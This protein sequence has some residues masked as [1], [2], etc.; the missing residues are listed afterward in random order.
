[1]KDYESY[2]NNG[3]KDIPDNTKLKKIEF[4]NMQFQDNILPGEYFDIRENALECDLNDDDKFAANPSEKGSANTKTDLNDAQELANA[5]NSGVPSASG[6]IVES[7]GA[8]AT[9]TATAVV[10]ASAAVVAFNAV[11]KVTPKDKYILQNIKASDLIKSKLAQWACKAA[12]K[13]GDTLY[14]IARKFN[15]TVDELK[16]LNNLVDDILSIGK[17]LIVK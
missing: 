14:N 9:G 11:T 10:G 7:A 8:I 6:S 16:K 15:T 3:N 17:I 5:A 12:V 2:R 13:A 4:C 1:M